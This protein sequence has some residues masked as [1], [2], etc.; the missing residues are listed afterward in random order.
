MIKIN[1][2]LLDIKERSLGKYQRNRQI[3]NG[4]NNIKTINAINKS[5]V[6]L[7]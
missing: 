3:N 6:L 1:N 5:K 7:K 2:D 4:E